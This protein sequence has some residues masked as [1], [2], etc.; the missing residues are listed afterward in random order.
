MHEILSD[1]LLDDNEHEDTDAVVEDV[2]EVNESESTL[3]VNSTSVNNI[4]PTAVSNG[5]SNC[6]ESSFEIDFDHSVFE[7]QIVSIP[8]NQRS[9]DRTDFDEYFETT[10]VTPSDI[11]G[12]DSV[13]V[14]NSQYLLHNYS[15]IGSVLYLLDKKIDAELYSFSIHTFQI[16]F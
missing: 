15:L 10:F 14:R 8:S 13:S 16:K 5:E 4:N 7:A 9:I 12:R 11:V 6:S 2:I 3:L 1:L